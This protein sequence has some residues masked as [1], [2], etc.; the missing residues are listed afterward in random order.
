MRSGVGR[1]WWRLRRVEIAYVDRILMMALF[2]RHVT[3]FLLAIALLMGMNWMSL[4]THDADFSP[5]MELSRWQCPALNIDTV[6]VDVDKEIYPSI[7][8]SG[9]NFGD[10]HR[11]SDSASLLLISEFYPSAYVAYN[12]TGTEVSP[13]HWQTESVPT[14]DQCIIAFSKEKILPSVYRFYGKQS[15]SNFGAGYQQTFVYFFGWRPISEVTG[16]C[17]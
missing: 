3:I 9:P 6:Y 8:L 15:C 7:F 17:S 1:G 5:A 2:L 12:S 13:Y 11:L 14:G 4:S 10:Y 16:G